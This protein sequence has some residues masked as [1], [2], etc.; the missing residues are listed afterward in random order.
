MIDGLGRTIDY[1]RISVT[2]R[3]N[4]RCLYCMPGDGIAIKDMEE[5]LSY[6]EIARVCNS[7][8]KLGIHKVK[9]TGGE[10]L[11]RRNIERLVSM[12]LDI[13]GIDEVTLTTNG[14]LLAEHVDSLWESGVRK[15]NVSLDTV[16]ADVY[17]SITGVDALDKVTC[18][19]EKALDKGF[20]LKT[21]T[22]IGR[23]LPNGSMNQCDNYIKVLEYFK[24]KNIANR[25]I[26]LMPIGVGADF[27]T[28][29]VDDLRDYIES[30]YGRLTRDEAIKGNG[31]A[32]YYRLD[33]F[34][35]AI[36]FIHPMNGK[37]CYECNRIRM[38]STGMIKP[39][40][41][42]EQGVDLRQIV[43]CDSKDVDDRIQSA[44]M[45]CIRSKP[46]EHCFDDRK[47]ISETKKM[48]MIGG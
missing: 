13:Q 28:V 46:K 20:C 42:Y 25:F 29:S 18:G 4:L 7:L 6:E 30:I 39:C 1:I 12:I 27:D 16:S 24:D 38:T 33:G 5:L 15:I 32:E 43:R 44:I 31:P 36:G 23:Y 3:C 8:A 37:F 35:G 41:C 10:P 14:V 11:V 2:D 47:N 48:V 17:K 26:E 40:L 21:N 19:I 9:L 34:K 45:S 22:V